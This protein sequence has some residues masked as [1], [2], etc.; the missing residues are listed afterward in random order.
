MLRYR[1][2]VRT[3][4]WAAMM[5][6]AALTPYFEPTLAI[7]VFPVCCYLALCAGVI[8]HN[9][10]HRTT[11]RATWLNR[12]FGAF[13]SVF[14]GYPTFAWVPTHNQNHHRFVNK[15]GDATITW[16]H[17]NRH[18]FFIAASYFFVSSYHQSAPIKE[19][20]R[21][22]RERNPALYRDIVGQ[23]ALW[24]GSHVALL[25]SAIAL[26]GGKQG[27]LLWALCF[28][29]PALFSL[30]T[31]IFFNYIQHVHTDPWSEHDHSRNFVGGLMNFLLFNNGF[32]TVH[33]GQPAAH[34]STLP[35]LH[36][37]IADQVHP[38]LQSSNFAWWLAKSYV[39]APLI[40]SMG[41][42]Q[43][44]RAPFDVDASGIVDLRAGTVDALEPGANVA[45]G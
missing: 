27:V 28:G 17:T 29:L 32:H 23:Y 30:W 13:L 26:H 35:A 33:H 10:N 44:G 16:R 43:I 38:S 11:F 8:A 45:R 2:D 39:L 5:P 12:A 9:H 22:A 18:N 14:Y 37:H 21:K 4:I 34:W 31:I 7:Y 3:L 42:R 15:A 40:P 36:A 19:Y 1:A 25:L 6:A 20:I 24:A 41:T